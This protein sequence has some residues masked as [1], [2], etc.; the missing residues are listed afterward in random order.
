MHTYTFYQTLIVQKAAEAEEL[1]KQ[2]KDAEREEILRE[3]RR[4]EAKRIAEKEAEKKRV[5]Y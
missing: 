2:K 4:E 5:I 1:E 3:K